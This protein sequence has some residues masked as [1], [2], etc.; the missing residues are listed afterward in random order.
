MLLGGQIFE[1]FS[2]T[3]QALFECPIRVLTSPPISYRGRRK[4]FAN[5]CGFP[6]EHPCTCAYT[7]PCFLSDTFIVQE[8][9][10]GRH[11]ET[12]IPKACFLNF[13]M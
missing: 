12:C 6:C 1:L 4:S 2:N 9:A 7:S 5:P 11:C 3:F 13:P 8:G 10:S